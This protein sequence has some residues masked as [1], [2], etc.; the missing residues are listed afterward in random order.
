MKHERG[1]GL[2]EFALVLPIL[3]GVM[4]MTVVV[5]DIFR[6]IQNI[7]NAASEGGRAAQVWRPDGITTCLS[8]ATEAA[9]RITPLDVDV[10]VSSN[11]GNWLWTRIPSGT[12]ITV[13]VTHTFEP[14]F[15]STILV[16]RDI[17]DPPYVFSYTALVED[18]HE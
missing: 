11:C 6:R 10:I 16:G 15:F 7:E 12:L 14:I 9:Q 5:G 3:C 13:E 8:A 2:V 17:G 18:C 1:Q 4:L